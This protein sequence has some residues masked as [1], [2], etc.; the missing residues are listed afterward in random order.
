MLLADWQQAK[1]KGGQVLHAG[2]KEVSGVMDILST[3][4]GEVW[5]FF[6]YGEAAVQ[7]GSRGYFR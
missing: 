6:F 3:V 5:I 4:G 1:A 2:E 7:R